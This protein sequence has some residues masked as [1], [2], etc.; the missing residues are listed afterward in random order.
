MINGATNRSPKVLSGS[1]GG[2]YVIIAAP[3]RYEIIC[4]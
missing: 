3:G 4:R 1:R 2:N